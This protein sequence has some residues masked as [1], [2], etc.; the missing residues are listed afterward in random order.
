MLWLIWFLISQTLNFQ[1]LG[2]PTIL[3]GWLIYENSIWW[4][5]R[6][7]NWRTHMLGKIRFNDFSYRILI[8]DI[9]NLVNNDR[10][11]Y[12]IIKI[13]RIFFMCRNVSW[14]S[15]WI[16]GAKSIKVIEFFLSFIDF[17]INKALQLVVF[18]QILAVNCCFLIFIHY[19]LHNI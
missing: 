18:N 12:F 9:L 17:R 1:L 16:T 10:F 3:H 19:K 4:L 5:L 2:I 13:F 7:F 11:L 15:S 14:R 8:I 6:P